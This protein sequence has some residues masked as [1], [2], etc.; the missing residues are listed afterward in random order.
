MVEVSAAAGAG[1]ALRRVSRGTSFADYD[2]DW[3]IDLVI[4]NLNGPPA[5]LCNDG[6][7]GNHY[8]LVR[9][10]G[11]VSNRD[12]DSDRQLAMGTGVVQL[13][14]R[15]QSRL[16]SLDCGSVAGPRRGAGR[17]GRSPKR[18]KRA[19]ARSNSVHPLEST[20]SQSA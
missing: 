16:G 19:G 11:T 6:D 5:L 1:F 7:H 10:V 3:D 15:P 20:L 2:G 4:L 13:A 14:A 17:R 12:G 9:T 8:L 18:A